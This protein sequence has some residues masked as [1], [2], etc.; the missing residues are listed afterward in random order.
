MTTYS[1]RRGKRSLAAILAAMLMASVLA[2][3]AGSPAQAANSSNEVLIDTNS[4]GVPDA[5]EFA[6]QDRYDTA[7][8]LAN[9]FAGRNKYSS[10][11]TVFVAS[12]ESLV[13]SISV[14]GLA[15]AMSAPVLLT[16]GDSLHGGVA[17][18]IEDHGVSQV[19]VLGGMAAISD[20]V[21]TAIE[22]LMNKPTA[23][24][25][26]GPD[27]YATAAAIAAKIPSATS[28]CG[29]TAA[30]AVLIN[31]ATDALPFGV[32]VGTMA[33]ALRVPVL[34]TAA[35]ELPASTSDYIRDNNVEHVQIIGGTDT[36]SADVAGALNTLGVDTVQRVDGETAAEVSVMLAKAAAAC[37]FAAGTSV[38]AVAADRVVLVRGN[39]DGVAAAPV[40]A[41]GI[42]GDPSS[43]L[44][45]PLIVGDSLP[46]VVR[47][48][49]AATPK[50]VGGNKLNLGIVAVGGTAAVSASVMDAA[51]EAAASTGELSVQIGASTDTNLDKAINADDPVRPQ[52]ANG[53]FTLYFSD[54]VTFD[55]PTEDPANPKLVSMLQD[56]IEVNGVPALISTATQGGV[57]CDSTK[58]NVTLGQP[59][60]DGDKISVVSSKHK[61]GTASDLRTVAPATATVQALAVDTGRPAVSIVGIA[62]T[63]SFY[64]AI[65]DAGGLAN[66]SADSLQV[67]DFVF[68]P[69]VRATTGASITGVTNTE[70]ATTSPVTKRM[71]AVV[72]IN[73]TAVPNVVL[74]DQLMAGDSLA[75]KEGVIKDL[76][77][78]RPNVNGRTSGTVIAAQA[79]PKIS[80]VL[81]SDPN[82]SAQNTWVVPST[83]VKG[84]TTGTYD[85]TITAKKNGGAAGAAGNAWRFVFDRAGTYNPTKPLDI[86]VRVDAV[87][88]RVT[89]RF[90]NGPLTATLGDLLAALKANPDFDARFSAAFTTCANAGMGVRE[91]LDL[92]TGPTGRNL[93]VTGA[94]A[95]RTK[96]AIEVH[97]D[98]YVNTVNDDELLADVLDYA[99]SRSPAA[100]LSALRA[101]AGASSGGLSITS[102]S[103]AAIVASTAPTIVVRYEAETALVRNLPQVG[104]RV[105]TEAGVVTEVLD[106]PFTSTVEA[107]YRPTKTPVA[108]GYAAN[109][110][111]TSTLIRADQSANAASI[112]PISAG[113]SRVK[114]PR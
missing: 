109:D 63:G 6:G 94:G 67:S 103:P 40:L 8:K 28:W 32:A 18:Y 27:R 80:S 104:D 79:S 19:Y 49:L 108:T 48:Y 113:G 100:D 53:V 97:F 34:M 75:L 64:V 72:T 95:G 21:V 16:Q 13:D 58:V 107:S 71:T 2:V 114:A 82:H 11:P 51:T 46:S 33:Y 10:V 70:V 45:T 66:R 78:P 12:G 93:E 37:Q 74:G 98:K 55:A 26:E 39:P 68:T 99:L 110:D 106:N 87:G 24:R 17:D 101:A 50:T 1:K 22:G 86:D 9:N 56:V 65:D 83:L 61:F 35:D 76:R 47:D 31:G 96:V 23:T 73:R 57:N 85:I 15:G 81:L 88:K 14:S 77:A 89:V 3:V 25:I 60:R 4:D 30:S 54:A 69:N 91:Q 42:S 59:L 90:N 43:G 44:I 111:R 5:R 29:T 52:T 102:A 84:A 38:G 112:V 92:E 20:A 105:V 36:V 62:G 41:T 7:L